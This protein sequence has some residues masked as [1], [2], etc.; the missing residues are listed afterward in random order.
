MTSRQRLSLKL[1]GQFHKEQSEQKK[2]LQV[3]FFEIGNK[4][5]VQN[6]KSFFTCVSN[7]TS[8]A[9]HL[10]QSRSIPPRSSLEFMTTK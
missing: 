5:E 8:I 6:T 4:G 10:S 9:C 1:N 7:S 2:I 3:R